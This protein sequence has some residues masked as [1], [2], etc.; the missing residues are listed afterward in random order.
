MSDN[1]HVFE[2]IRDIGFLIQDLKPKETVWF[3]VS[4]DDEIFYTARGS[5]RIPCGLS[6]TSQAIKKAYEVTRNMPDKR[7]VQIMEL[8]R[9]LKSCIDNE[10][11][12]ENMLEILDKLLYKNYNIKRR[13]Y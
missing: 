3:S 2:I 11:I 7:D 6:E 10:I 1:Q 9:A 12:G 13:S 5:K 4:K 8:K